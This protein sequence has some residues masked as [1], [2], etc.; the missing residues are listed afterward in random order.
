MTYKV[1]HLD[2]DE[3]PSG[4]DEVVEYNEKYLV[5]KHHPIFLSSPGR[6]STE[7]ERK[8]ATIR[9]YEEVLKNLNEEF[10]ELLNRNKYLEKRAVDDE[11]QIAAKNSHIIN[12]EAKI[13][14]LKSDLDKRDEQWKAE[15]QRLN[16][17]IASLQYQLTQKTDFDNRIKNE[18]SNLQLTVQNLEIMNKKLSDS[19]KQMQREI[20][21]LLERVA[22]SETETRNKGSIVNNFNLMKETYKNN[23]AILEANERKLQL[24]LANERKARELLEAQVHNQSTKY[25]DE[26]FQITQLSNQVESLKKTILSQNEDIRVYRNNEQFL[27]NELNHQKAINVEQVYTQPLPVYEPA[28]PLNSSLDKVKPLPIDLETPIKQKDLTRDRKLEE[29]DRRAGIQS[30]KH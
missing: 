18:K 29:F 8:D 27:K 17:E 11:N 5:D 23:M 1:V 25:S 26:Q 7:E 13:Q 2:D 6:Y 24:D 10:R 4:V 12:L 16:K 22:A 28:A 30:Q 3:V 19:E 14:D 21:S 20:N 9:K 15:H